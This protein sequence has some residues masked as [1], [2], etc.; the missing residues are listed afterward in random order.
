MKNYLYFLQLFY[1][2][3]EFY[4]MKNYLYFL[5]LF[6]VV[7]GFYLMK[8]YLYFLQLFYV[9]SGYYQNAPGTCKELKKWAFEIYSTFLVAAGSV[10]FIS[11]IRIENNSTLPVQLELPF[12]L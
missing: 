11:N 3:S 12:N 10:S 4:L 7:S 9:V 1:I 6:Y 5:Q 8:N 2:V